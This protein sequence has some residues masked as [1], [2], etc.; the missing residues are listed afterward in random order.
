[1][2]IVENEDQNHNSSNKLNEFVPFRPSISKE[3]R[4]LK[5]SIDN[6]SERRNKQI[7]SKTSIS[8][9]NH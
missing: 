3:Q 8:F 4:R 9:G 1:M 6:N 5:T 2:E 7:I